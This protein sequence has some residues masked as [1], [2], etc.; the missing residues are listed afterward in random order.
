MG[1]E[2]QLLTELANAVEEVGSFD[3]RNGPI[4]GA[5]YLRNADKFLALA[6]A[7][8]KSEELERN[9]K[10]VASISHMS[11]QIQSF[12]AE[13]NRFIQNS[14][15][16]EETLYA[17]PKVEIAL[18]RNALPKGWVVDSTDIICSPFGGRSIAERLGTYITVDVE[19][20]GLDPFKN[21]I[22]EIAAVRFM[23]FRPVECFCT[24]IHPHYGLQAEA[25]AVNRITSDMLVN[26]PSIESVRNSFIN[27][28]G[29][30]M[31]II[32][33]NVSFDLRFLYASA[34][35]PYPTNR[36]FFDTLAQSRKLYKL[37]SYRL[38]FLDRAVLRIARDDAH[39]ALSD[40]LLTGF[41]FKNLCLKKGLG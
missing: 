28:V 19:T 24:Y 11:K 13:V 36:P 18:E 34:C 35:L 1:N 29:K 8:L 25:A 32:G 23:G 12:R 7:A 5:N 9:P 27:F 30:T 37:E 26:A 39:S 22:I 4:A 40:A 41:L 6:D 14:A 38:D 10:L 16:F 15:E 3:F 17:L 33:H 31:A 21:E 20:S 2:R